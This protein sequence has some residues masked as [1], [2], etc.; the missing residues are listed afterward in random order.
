MTTRGFANAPAS[1]AGLRDDHR[2]ARSAGR[3]RGGEPIGW[4]L[5]PWRCLHRAAANLAI[6]ARTRR[7]DRYLYFLIGC[8]PVFVTAANVLAGGITRA[9][10]DL[11]WAFL[12]PGYAMLAL[13][14]LRATPWFAVFVGTVVLA[15]AIDPIVAG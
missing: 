15:M 11:V 7:F 9:G 4:V 3:R 1:A 14:P 6:L 5:E 8:G 13:G 2:A 10:G 12:V